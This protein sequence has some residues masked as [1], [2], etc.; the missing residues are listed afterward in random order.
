MKTRMFIFLA[1]ISF[2]LAAAC[3]HMA[4]R[5]MALCPILQRHPGL[6]WG[7]VILF[8]IL[9]FGVPLLHRQLS[10]RINALYW[11]SYLALSLVSTYF[12]YLVGADFV[13]MVSRRF[14]GA[15]DSAG[16]WAFFAAASLTIA[17][18][19]I[20]LVQCYV[21]IRTNRIEVPIAG[22]PDGL[23]GFRIVQ[24]SDLHLGPLLSVARVERIVA[25]ANDLSPDLIA[26]TGD[27]ADGDVEQERPCLTA[28]GKLQALHGVRFIT[29]N[30][31]YYSG[32]RPWLQAV[33]DLGWKTLLNEHEI[34]G[35]RNAELAVIGLPD[36]AGKAMGEGP[37]LARAMAGIPPGT[38]KLLLYHQPLG[39]EKAARAGIQV[40]LSGHTHGGQYFP[41]SPIVRMLF[42]HPVGLHRQG[43]MWIYTSPGTGFWGPPNRFLVPPEITLITLRREPERSDP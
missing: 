30:H 40:Q 8:L 14:L 3:I 38:M 32:V 7:A 5:S 33:R 42:D 6:V 9:Q 4:R 34:L 13:Q 29:G 15:P 37:D 43:S 26:V 36:P 19:S 24:I 39:A 1:I 10:Y 2:V 31:E 27:L 11:A 41:W 18:A 23:E 25:Q 12:L 21:P 20:G 28:L 22:L 35:H 17:S 16:Q